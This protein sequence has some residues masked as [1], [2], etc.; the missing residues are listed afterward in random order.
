ME[1][2]K[3]YTGKEYLESIQDDREIW[4]YGERVTNVVN[5][6]AFRNT[7]R[8]IARLYDSLYDEKLRDVLT[9]PTDTKDGSFTHKFYRIPHSAEDLV[10]SRDAIAQWAR[11]T[12]GWMGRTPDY[13]ASFQ[14]ALGS[15]PD[16]WG[17]YN[18]NAVRWYQTIQNRCLFLNHAGINPPVDRNLPPD[19]VGDVYV[20][21]EKETDA[22]VI[23]SGAKVVATGSAL[24]HVN[25]VFQYGPSPIKA[26]KEFTLFAMV[27]M[28]TPG[29]K[30]ICRP[31]YEM[32]AE[33]MGSPFDYPLSS[34]LDENDAVLIFDHAFIPWENVMLYGNI[35]KANMF[36]PLSG[37]PQRFEFHGCVR[38]AV[39]LDFMAGMM[40]KAVDATG[41]KDFRGVQAQLGEIIA[42]RNLFWAL[43]DAMARTPD[44]WRDGVVEP[45]FDYGNAYRVFATVAW[46]RVKEII[47]QTVAS[48]LIYINSN[49]RDFQNPEIRPLLDK[50]YRGSNGYSGV[51]KMKLMKLLWD[52]T[53][54]EFAG[55]HELY[56]RNYAGNHENIRMETLFTAMANG[57]ADQCKD[58][59]DRC[60][61]EYD[62]D[63]WTVP[64]L[65]NPRDVSYFQREVVPES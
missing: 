26:K 6:P 22:G 40:L 20:H 62:L 12:Y 31:S 18:I 11:M 36:V 52:A 21:V 17:D 7:A 58:L 51:D 46:P 61:S 54:S 2:V 42:W 15:N 43:T 49:S 39:K 55:R 13:K 35:E 9:V 19:E 8:M 14:V 3:P 64:D 33:V 5:H 65:V 25:F 45:N 32:T 37:W 50:Y 30:L 57:V 63:G 28:N 41:A 60:L 59:V 38:L 23:V 27:P 10:A 1:Q 34:R 16:Y 44:P 56:E 4:I 53:G 29:L 24:T 48:G 47:E